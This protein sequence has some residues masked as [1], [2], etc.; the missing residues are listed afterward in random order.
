MTRIAI[1]A[2][3]V[4]LA[5]VS[6]VVAGAWNRSGDP[7]LAIT[8]SERELPITRLPS[9]APGEDPG[10]LLRID[11]QRRDDP[12]DARNWLPESR[13][14]ELGFVFETPVGAPQA[15]DAYARVPSRIAWVALE[16]GG[17]AW[18]DIERRQQ[19]RASEG[20]PRP[21]PLGSRLVPVD[22]ARDFESL[23]VR[24]PSGHLII[25][26]LIGVRYV[27]PASGGPLVHGW[28][29]EIVPARV[30][31]PAHLRG[32]FDGMMTR[33]EAPDA[34]PRYEAELAIGRL[35]LP[36]LRSARRLD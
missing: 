4:M 35:G 17:P 13:L 8:L 15:A 9:V 22:A 12:L 6:F 25:R 32:V 10:L 1:P 5:V 21:M 31:V 36:Y 7:Q 11:V 3:T 26:A 34:G 14:A 33:P 30:A 16:Y 18:Q 20:P 23:R 29:R 24:Y 27:P 19:L 2:L 28:L